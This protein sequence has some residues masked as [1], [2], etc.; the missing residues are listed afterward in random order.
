L[1]ATGPSAAAPPRAAVTNGYAGGH[2]LKKLTTGIILA[3]AVAAALSSTGCGKKQSGTDAASGGS[4]AVEA[5]PPVAKAGDFES[6]WKDLAARRARVRSYEMVLTHEGKKSR[7]SLKMEGDKIV[8][9]RVDMGPEGWMLAQFDKKVNYVFDPRAGV[10]MKMPM[11][12]KDAESA[13]GDQLPGVDELKGSNPKISEDRVDGVLCWRV[14]APDAGSAWLDKEYGLLRQV[15]QG[16]QVQ[17]IAY[18]RINAVPDSVFELP[19]GTKVQDMSGMM[20]NM[21][22][23]PR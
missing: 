10:V 7:H 12:G 9:M 4:Q 16:D 11:S 19:A 22:G 17:K 6:T 14:D 15:K 2:V 18:E 21:P 5:P 20:K 13:A 3:V 23:A 8:R 1:T